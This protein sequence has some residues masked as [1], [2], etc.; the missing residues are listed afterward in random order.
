MDKPLFLIVIFAARIKT[1]MFPHKPELLTDRDVVKMN[2]LSQ[3]AADQYGERRAKN[4]FPEKKGWE[5]HIVA[6]P[7]PMEALVPP[8]RRKGL[9]YD[10]TKQYLSDNFEEIKQNIIWKQTFGF[11]EE[12][13][14]AVQKS[15]IISFMQKGHVNLRDHQPVIPKE[16]KMFWEKIE[17][18]LD[19]F[20]ESDDAISRSA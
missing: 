7:I 19:S 10:L 9:E 13:R 1:R 12:K 3:E 17:G 14:L 11:S 18:Y 4:K 5:T 6:S 8:S 16:R 20:L 15:L 2:F